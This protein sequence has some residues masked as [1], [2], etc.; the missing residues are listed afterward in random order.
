MIKHNSYW[1][2][3]SEDFTQLVFKILANDEWISFSEAVILASKK[4]AKKF[5][6]GLYQAMRYVSMLDRG[7]ALP[8]KNA[9]KIALYEELYKRFVE[10]RNE[11]KSMGI[12]TVLY[13]E[14][15]DIINSPAPCFYEDVECLRKRC[16]F[17]LNIKK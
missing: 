10:Y 3:K 7:K 12:N 15:E 2:E 14:I 16:Y 5:Y 6:V 4:P 11:R 9:N 13:S 17:Y 8:L 1:A